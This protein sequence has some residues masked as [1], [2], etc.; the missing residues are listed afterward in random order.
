M[1]VNQLDYGPL[2][3]IISCSDSK[4]VYYVNICEEGD[5]V[6]LKGPVVQDF[7]ASSGRKAKKRRK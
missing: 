6:I 4:P 5:C 7:V 3:G 2:F 1:N